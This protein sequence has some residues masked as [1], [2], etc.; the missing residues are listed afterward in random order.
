[1]KGGG[2]TEQVAKDLEQWVKKMKCSGVGGLDIETFEDVTVG[3]DSSPLDENNCK[4]CPIK[5]EYMENRNSATKEVVNGDNFKGAMQRIINSS[6]ENVSKICEEYVEDR[7]K[8]GWRHDREI[9]E[10]RGEYVA[11]FLQGRARLVFQ[12]GNSID[13]YFV[14]GVLHGFARYFDPRGRLVFI[15][16]HRNGLCEGTCWRIIPGGGCV[17]GRVDRR[18]ELTG[19]RIAYIYP[20]YQTALLGAFKDGVMESGRE[21]EVSGYVED[22]AGIKIPIFSEQGT[23]IHLRN[24][25][26]AGQFGKGQFDNHLLS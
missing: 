24:V 7:W 13:G 2:I 18:G 4:Y 19:P 3:I 25:R 23:S 15:G 21:A 14:R 5:D 10:I 6:C 1:M 9:V 8:E 22:D 20:D 11:G 16:Q 17:V 12:H 26:H